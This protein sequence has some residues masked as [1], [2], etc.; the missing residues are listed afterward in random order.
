MATTN[1]IAGT[2]V[3]VADWANEVDALVHDVFGA[4]ATVAAART[5]LSVTDENIQDLIGAMVANSATI[6]WTYNDAAGT[7]SAAVTFPTENYD[8][9]GCTF[10]APANSDLIM[11]HVA[12][13]SL[14][15]PANMSGTQIYVGTN[16]SSTA[17]LTL[18]KNGVSAGAITIS[19]AGAV[20]LPTQAA[21]SFVAGDRI[22]LEVTTA[23]GIN[24]LIFTFKATEA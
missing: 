8:I 17:T 4:A 22:E 21:V 18:K 3:I 14:T 11:R 9:G 6:T 2:T 20:T 23:A 13:R 16:P 15:L 5:A 12:V 24:N 7:L 19:S 1:F 10:S